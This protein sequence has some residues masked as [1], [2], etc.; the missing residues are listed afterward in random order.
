MRT[1]FL[2]AVLLLSGPRIGTARNAPSSLAPSSAPVEAAELAFALSQLGLEWLRLDWVAAEA[3]KF[4]R[5]RLL[6]K[7]TGAPSINNLSWQDS[8]KVKF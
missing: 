6:D 2:L 1:M 7:Q 3:H 5:R 4:F 8:K